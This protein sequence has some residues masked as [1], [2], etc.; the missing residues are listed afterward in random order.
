[1][2]A[3]RRGVARKRT[4][5]CRGRAWERWLL[6]ALGLAGAL[7]AAMTAHAHPDGNQAA[8]PV[9]NLSVDFA[10]GRATASR[11]HCIGSAY[12][13][14]RYSSTGGWTW[15]TNRF[16]SQSFGWGA[17]EAAVKDRDYV[18]ARAVTSGDP[19][20]C[21][22][23]AYTS[24]IVHART[25]LATNRDALTRANLDRATLTVTLGSP[26]TT[27]TT[28]SSSF[29]TFGSGVGASGFELVTNPATPGLS[30][31]VGTVTSGSRT[32]TLTL[33]TGSNYVNPPTSVAVRVKAAAHSGSTALTSKTLPVQTNPGLRV[34]AV[35]GLATEGGGKATFP[36]RLW[37]QPSAA[38]TVSVSS[39]DTSEGT[40]A[41]SSI[42]FSTTSWNTA[43][44]VTVTGVDDNV[45]D[46]HVTWQVRLDPSSGDTDYDGLSNVVVGVTTL[47]DDLPLVSST[48]WEGINVGTTDWSRMDV[49][50][51]SLRDEAARQSVTISFN[52]GGAVVW[53]NFGVEACEWWA[54]TPGG[55]HRRVPHTP[56]G[57]AWGYV[58]SPS[59]A[60]RHPDPDHDSQR[61]GRHQGDADQSW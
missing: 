47:D 2:T 52:G 26:A 12:L 5:T 50:T 39:R 10:T 48:R 49:T 59:D 3:E 31:T 21:P 46:G 45:N 28:S 57:R 25:T 44:T 55:D 6:G 61:W 58:V 16:I 53:A 60:G 35:S 33:S 13:Q 40:V 14:Y 43:Q 20:H 30:F 42:T 54:V 36:V 8:D 11:P 56:A 18:E 7:A 37:T 29:A 4:P 32:A 9:T 15:G 1:M 19:P 24:A 51:T 27:L 22:R 23:P 38:V 34:G 17:T 41:P